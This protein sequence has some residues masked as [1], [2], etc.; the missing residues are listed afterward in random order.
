MTPFILLAAGLPSLCHA[1]SEFDADQR[2]DFC[3]RYYGDARRILTSLT[4]SPNI[5]FDGSEFRPDDWNSDLPTD[6]LDLCPAFP[7]EFDDVP[8]QSMH[9]RLFAADGYALDTTIS[10]LALQ[11]VL[12]TNGSGPGPWPSDDTPAILAPHYPRYEGYDPV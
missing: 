6:V 5:N 9:V 2:D 12:I 11:D 4:Q 7:N 8:E 10:H 3:I 1:I